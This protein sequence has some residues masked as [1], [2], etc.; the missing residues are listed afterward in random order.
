[1]CSSE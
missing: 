1:M